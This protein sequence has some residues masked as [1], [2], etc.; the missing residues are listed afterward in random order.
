MR[1]REGRERVGD[2]VLLPLGATRP[3][4]LARDHILEM[5]LMQNETHRLE[6][7][8]LKDEAVALQQTIATLQS[9]QEGSKSEDEARRVELARLQVLC[10]SL[11]GQNENL[12]Q[13]N[14]TLWK[15]RVGLK[16]ELGS[17][18]L[19]TRALGGHCF[20]FCSL[21]GVHVCV[22]SFDVARF[23]RSARM[24]SVG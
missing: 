6:I 15:E 4:V 17:V 1:W 8:T 11:K 5:K 14:A 20:L 19:H 16:E 3:Q 21:S 7:A 18:S 24:T 9:K 13:E 23:C 10:E 22:F 12:S 2:G